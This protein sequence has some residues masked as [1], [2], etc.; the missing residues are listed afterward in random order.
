MLRLAFAFI[1]IALHRRGPEQLPASTFLLGLVF[2]VYLATAFATL[3]L[4]PLV[5]NAAL[6]LAFGIVMYAGFVWAV[7]KAFQHEKRFKQTA[8]ALLGTETFFNVLSLPVLSWYSPADDT[9]DAVITAP[10]L[11]LY[12]LFFWSVDV[13]GFVLSRAIGRPYVV[14]VFIMIGYALLSISIQVSLF[15]PSTS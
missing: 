11:L 4:D 5:E 2:V 8:T 1:D 14:G 7:L 9:L 13:A 12:I 10:R 15:P 3:R 6:I